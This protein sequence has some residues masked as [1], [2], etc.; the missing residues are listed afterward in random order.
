MPDKPERLSA[1]KRFLFGN[2]SVTNSLLHATGMWG[3]KEPEAKAELA[4]VKRQYALEATTMDILGELMVIYHQQQFA[5]E[6]MA[7]N[8]KDENVTA[9]YHNTHRLRLNDHI[10]LLFRMSDMR[11]KQGR[12]RT[13]CPEKE[14]DQANQYAET[15]KM[16]FTCQEAQARQGYFYDQ[17]HG[18]TQPGNNLLSEAVAIRDCIRMRML[19]KSQYEDYMIAKLLGALTED[20]QKLDP[21]TLS[22]EELITDL[23]TWDPMEHAAPGQTQYHEHQKLAQIIFLE[24]VQQYNKVYEKAAA[25]VDGLLDLHQIQPGMRFPFVGLPPVVKKAADGDPMAIVELQ[26]MVAKAKEQTPEYVSKQAQENRNIMDF[27]KA[28]TMGLALLLAFCS[29]WMCMTMVMGATNDVQIAPGESP[30]GDHAVVE[31]MNEEIISRLSS[32]TMHTATEAMFITNPALARDANQY[33]APRPPATRRG[34]DDR[35]FFQAFSSVP[36]SSG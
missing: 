1:Y 19:P 30:A 32:D 7:R 18:I 26:L 3:L 25:H 6:L 36:A 24:R 12:N 10:A 31:T 21:E 29:V 28:C 2:I 27:G 35:A 4:E 23:H 20:E 16:N 15:A 17:A 9:S 34:L 11:D 13:E 5:I 14:V 8:L 33:S 22:K